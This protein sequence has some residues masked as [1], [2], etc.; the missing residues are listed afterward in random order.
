MAS[1]AR[2]RKVQEAKDR[3]EANGLLVAVNANNEPLVRRMLGVGANPDA[4]EDATHPSGVK[5]WDGDSALYL[6]LDQKN[7]VIARLLLE[8]GATV[9]LAFGDSRDTVLMMVAMTNMLMGALLLFKHHANPNVADKNKSTALHGAVHEGH[10]E[11]AQLLV[12]RGAKVDAQDRYGETALYVAANNGHVKIVR[13]LVAAGATL[14][15]ASRSTPSTLTLQKRTPAR[16][17][18]V[19]KNFDCLEYLLRH[20][21]SAHLAAVL[22]PVMEGVEWSAVLKEEVRSLFA[23]LKEH[24]HIVH[25]LADHGGIC[26]KSSMEFNIAKRTGMEYASVGKEERP[27]AVGLLEALRQVG[28]DAWCDG[29]RSVKWHAMHAIDSTKLLEETPCCDALVGHTLQLRLRP[30]LLEKLRGDAPLGLDRGDRVVLHGLTSSLGVGLNGKRG[31]IGGA[32]GAVKAGRYPVFFKGTKGFKQILPRN[33]RP[34]VKDAERALVAGHAIDAIVSVNIHGCTGT[35]AVFN[36]TYDTARG[37][38]E[39]LYPVLTHTIHPRARIVFTT[40][41]RWHIGMKS[42]ALEASDYQPKLLFGEGSLR[43]RTM[44]PLLLNQKWEIA[45]AAHCKH[46]PDDAVVL[47]AP[48]WHDGESPGEWTLRDGVV[49]SYNE[50]SREHKIVFCDHDRSVRHL[51]LSHY[52]FL[53]WNVLPRRR[54]AMLAPRAA[55]TFFM[56]MNR[57][58][59]RQIPTEAPLTVRMR[60][61]PAG[62]PVLRV[63]MR[64]WMRTDKE[65]EFFRDHM[66]PHVV[67]PPNLVVRRQR[68]D[69]RA[70]LAAEA[71]AAAASG[72]GSGKKRGGKTK[73]KKKRKGKK[74]R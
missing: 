29:G 22:P 68:E 59:A 74:G 16:I 13:L 2:H 10:D 23:V 71:T 8:A 25:L 38:V 30:S 32:L 35:H 54:A 17:A 41:G 69:A 72:G 6:A 37:E 36:G 58:R 12:E 18:L 42:E 3:V 4:Q 19:S 15:L 21:A 50:R 44:T 26:E 57:M 24:P 63:M 33:V 60:D 31:K 61:W 53:D 48:R 27:R 62:T 40:S 43:T 39:N 65:F 47:D 64:V 67:A 73:T 1:E 34:I 55:M 28:C 11:M 7:L 14:D 5:C 20:G 46:V 52:R 9:N 56:I 66:W 49:E 70:A 45:S 51:R